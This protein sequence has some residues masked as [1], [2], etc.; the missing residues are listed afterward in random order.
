GHV[1]LRRP[2][3]A[4]RGAAPAN[5]APA[6]DARPEPCDRGREPLA[7]R[8]AGHL[9]SVSARAVLSRLRR[10]LGGACRGGRLR[11]RLRGFH[12]GGEAARRPRRDPRRPRPSPLERVG[13]GLRRGRPRRLPVR[14]GAAPHGSRRTPLRG[15]LERGAG[16]RPRR[17]PNLRRDR[18]RPHRDP[19]GR[20]RSAKISGAGDNGGPAAPGD[21][22]DRSGARLR[23][24]V[25]TPRASGIG[26]EAV[27]VR[28][29]RLAILPAALAVAALGSGCAGGDHPTPSS[30]AAAP[31]VSAPAPPAKTV[32]YPLGSTTIAR[33]VTLAL[34]RIVAPP[35]APAEL[36]IDIAN[37]S[38]KSGP[39]LEFDAS[40]IVVRQAGR[41][42]SLKA[43]PSAGLTYGGSATGFTVQLTG[44]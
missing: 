35:N 25:R 39:D 7:R 27:S 30:T 40:R 10:A 42:I 33:G 14:V 8:A 18:V 12:G 2:A 37:R 26:G 41:R 19:G 13:G 15:D 38:K 11:R 31:V 21:R 29:M 28:C 22:R 44:F 16:R 3:P 23:R 4:P 24:G 1:D 9:R 20:D 32:T 36:L 43:G 17:G 5:T 6:D 34:K